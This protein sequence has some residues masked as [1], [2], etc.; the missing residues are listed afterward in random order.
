MVYLFEFDSVSFLW[1]DM[2]TQWLRWST[3]LQAWGEE[4]QGIARGNL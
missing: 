1:L 4:G 3:A 2:R